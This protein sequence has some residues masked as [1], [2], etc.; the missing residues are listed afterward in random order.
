MIKNF[1]I[2][3]FQQCIA[4][5]NH[6]SGVG[7]TTLVRKVCAVLTEHHHQVA[8]QGFY[9]EEVRGHYHGASGGNVPRLGFD[10]VSLT[11]KR[12]PLARVQR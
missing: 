2:V 12:A 5:T 8:L 4:N 1:C 10:V 7:K 9:T 3:L 6:P 11:G